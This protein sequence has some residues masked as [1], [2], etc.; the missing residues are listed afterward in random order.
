MFGNQTANNQPSTTINH[1]QLDNKIALLAQAID[2]IKQN[3]PAYVI[4][5]VNKDRKSVV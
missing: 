4:E 1:Q 3:Y 2:E 5:L